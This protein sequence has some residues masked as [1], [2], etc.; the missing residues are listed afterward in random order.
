MDSL[1][2]PAKNKGGRQIIC[3]YRI[4]KIYISEHVVYV[5]RLLLYEIMQLPAHLLAIQPTPS[6]CKVLKLQYAI[7]L[8]KHKSP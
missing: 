2:P 4:V 5:W 1:Y 6:K 3:G 8:E 7:C